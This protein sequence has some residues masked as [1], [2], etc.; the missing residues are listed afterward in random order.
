MWESWC[1]VGWLV[2]ALKVW[3]RERKLMWK[4][5]NLEI[6]FLQ[7]REEERVQVRE[8]DYPIEARCLAKFDTPCNRV[9]DGPRAHRPEAVCT[10]V[11]EAFVM[12]TIGSP[13]QCVFSSVPRHRIAVGLPLICWT[14]FSRPPCSCLARGKSP[15]LGN[16]LGSHVPGYWNT[17]YPSSILCSSHCL[18]PEYYDNPDFTLRWWQCSGC[19]RAIIWQEAG[20]VEQ[21]S[22]ASADRSHGAWYRREKLTPLFFMP[23]GLWGLFVTAA[24][25]YPNQYSKLMQGTQSFASLASMLLSRNGPESHKPYS[26]PQTLFKEKIT[27]VNQ[28]AQT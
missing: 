7:G 6:I 5:G 26:K 11:G 13:I 22:P 16:V 27:L 19:K 2:C 3:D 10:G 8:K 1:G 14:T 4:L 15:H 9:G 17:G 18:E 21:G 20:S 24:K 28:I 12:R 23:L 25:P